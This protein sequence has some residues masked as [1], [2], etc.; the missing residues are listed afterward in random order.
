[1]SGFDVL[2]RSQ[3]MMQQ[4]SLAYDKMRMDADARFNQSIEQA[5]A[6]FL[7]ARKAESDL[8]IQEQQASLA[9]EM[10]KLQMSNALEQSRQLKLQTQQADLALKTAQDQFDRR[11]QTRATEMQRDRRDSNIKRLSELQ[12][13]GMTLSEDGLRIR[14]M[15]PEELRNYNRGDGIAESNL[16]LRRVHEARLALDALYDLAKGADGTVRINK[17]SPQ[18]QQQVQRLQGLVFGADYLG[19]PTAPV[20]PA[21]PGSTG[22]TPAPVA[23]EPTTDPGP[24]VE[25]PQVDTGLQGML[26]NENPLVQQQFGVVANALSAHTSRPVVESMSPE[27]AGSFML[28]IARVAGQQV[29]MGTLTAEYAGQFVVDQFFN[30]QNATLQTY[31]MA[32]AG[33]DD[34]QIRAYL[35]SRPYLA[36]QPEDKRNKT[37]ESVLKQIRADVPSTQTASQ[38]GQPG[39]IIETDPGGEQR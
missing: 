14:K 22:Q 7:A 30:G 11:D 23:P 29:E 18:Q 33:L 28:G 26:Q 8:R 5:P 35:S 13:R 24:S 36:S 6:K 15:T 31:V 20:A 12:K 39:Y 4:T 38:E 10:G 25:Q 16:Q 17:L 3:Q 9:K 19:D 2:M 37:I 27:Q 21:G 1:M 32:A 34:D